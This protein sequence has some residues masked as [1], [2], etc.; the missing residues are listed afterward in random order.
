VALGFSPLKLLR[1][2]KKNIPDTIL[3]TPAD[4]QA[5]ALSAKREVILSEFLLSSE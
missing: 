5:Q 1:L 4:P 3:Y 2:L